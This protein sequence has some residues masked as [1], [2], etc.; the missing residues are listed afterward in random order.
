MKRIISLIGILFFLSG[1]WSFAQTE[2]SDIT[3]TLTDSVL[4]IKG[5]GSMPEYSPW[6]S[7]P[8]ISP[9]EKHPG[10]KKIIIEEGITSIGDY[11]FRLLPNLVAVELPQNL[12][13]I[14]NFAFEDC[15]EF[16]T[17]NSLDDIEFF[18]NNAFAGCEKL[19]LPPINFFY[20]TK[21]GFNAFKDCKGLQS[22]SL[23]SK[24]MYNIESYAF[25]GSDLAEVH[26]PDDAPYFIRTGL[27]LGCKKLTSIIIPEVVTGIE[28]STFENSGLTSIDIPGSVKWISD[29]TFAGSDLESIRFPANY[30]GTEIREETFIGTKLKNLAVPERVITIYDRAFAEC[31]ELT[32][33]T[34]PASLESIRPD[35]FRNCTKLT[36]IAIPAMYISKAFSGSGLTSV[37]I[38]SSVKHFSGETF[39]GCNHL[40]TI[41]VVEDNQNFSS[42]EGVVFNKDKTTIICYPSGKTDSYYSIPSSVKTIEEQVFCGI[43]S[44]KVVVIPESVTAIQQEAFHINRLKVETENP[45]PILVEVDAF[46]PKS[47]VSTCTLIVPD[48]TVQQYKNAKVWRDFGS[49]IEKS[50]VSNE[51][52]YS[53]ILPIVYPNPVKNEL[54]I[55]F[56]YSHIGHSCKI[57]GM[58]GA[59]IT[60]FVISEPKTSIDVSRY[61]AGVYLVVTGNRNQTVK[62][63]RMR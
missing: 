62:F 17:I 27:F 19:Q 43:D 21:I 34:L 50:E 42:V 14:G 10:I 3:S 39:E 44:L 30:E 24:N 4:V 63:V 5:K 31:S 35:A 37:E 15:K 60:E 29:R 54:N 47:V 20:L 46:G 52:V 1:N 45:E 51:L 61:P 11:T 49:I 56:S 53:D 16:T 9:W 22:I 8:S 25:E 2:E 59:L 58:N 55:E 26:L 6:S 32:S 33:I 7:R 13:S 18:G 41:N 12:T 48:G 38:L 36:T 23:Y 28:P 57:F 40:I